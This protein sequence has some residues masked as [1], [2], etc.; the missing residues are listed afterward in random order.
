MKRS[1]VLG[2]ILLELSTMRRNDEMSMNI[3]DKL[4]EAG[5]LPPLVNVI[6]MEESEVDKRF[7]DITVFDEDRITVTGKVAHWEAEDDELL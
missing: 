2:L 6:A 7:E 5:M 4:E 1:D 3:L